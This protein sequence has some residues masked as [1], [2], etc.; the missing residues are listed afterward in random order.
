M[1]GEGLDKTIQ[2]LQDFV[3]VNKVNRMLDEKAILLKKLSHFDKRF[4]VNS[5]EEKTV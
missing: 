2:K 5:Q 1:I 4:K 3:T